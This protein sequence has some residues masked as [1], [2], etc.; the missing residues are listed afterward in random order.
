MISLMARFSRGRGPVALADQ[1]MISASNFVAG[2]V[3]VRGLGLSE[4]GKYTIAYALLLYANSLQ[5]SFISS[6][7]L[8]VAP[9]MADR[10][11][12]Q[13]V[14]GML[15]IQI[16]AS[17]LLFLVFG[18]AGSI[19]HIFKPFFSLSCT[20]AFACCVGTCQ[21]QDWLR[22]YYFLYNRGKLAIVSDFIS[23][24]G[25]L[26]LLILLWRVHGLTLF[27]TFLV[28]CGTSIVA[29]IMG[30]V[31]DHLRP[32]IGH[33]REAWAHCRS[34]SRDLLI[35]NQVR[36]FGAQGVLL[37]GTAIIG[38]S[39]AGGLRAAQNLSG[40]VY[41]FLI[42]IENV[43]PIRI[44]RELKSKGTVGAYALIQRAIFTGTIIFSLLIVPVGIFG[45]SILRILYGPTM[46]AFYMPMLL[47][48][49][50]IVVQATI[51]MWFYLYRGV[52]DTRALLGANALCAFVN[53]A[54]V[55][56]FGHF[57]QATGIMLSSLC[58]Q[59][60][61]LAYCMFYWRRH[62][63]ELVARYPPEGSSKPDV[64]ASLSNV[65][66]PQPSIVD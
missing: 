15:T 4:F 22:R 12:R 42:A 62:R 48:L 19:V 59:V 40:P 46:D 56:W 31:T 41:L 32:A 18:L 1:I 61:T 29:V 53:V 45:R 55:Y 52:R 20:L 27:R 17:V 14:N 43:V 44:A 2:I 5:M 58:A 21:L 57:W 16:L 60:V 11:K 23:Y 38:T 6:P 39:A 65:I 8:S 51:T 25:Q 47:Q 7:M 50:A 63:D 26:M 49:I 34:L 28:M 24:V 36:W 30:P 3:L 33:L 64:T 66:N 54:T 37:I 13:F 9:L 35:A 10:A